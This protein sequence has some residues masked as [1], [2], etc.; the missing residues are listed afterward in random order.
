MKTGDGSR[1]KAH[2][3]SVS[4]LYGNSLRPLFLG[5]IFICFCSGCQLSYL[6]HLAGGQIEMLN[7]SVPIK[8]ALETEDFTADQRH[9]LEMVPEIKEFGESILGLRKTRNYE[10]VYPEPRKTPMYVLSASD[11]GC[12]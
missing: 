9:N 10:T 12:G 6:L 4:P 1:A 11:K 7:G 2:K 3:R 5:L 8:S